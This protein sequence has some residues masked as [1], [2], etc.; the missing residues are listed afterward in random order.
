MKNSTLIEKALKL[1]S[2]GKLTDAIRL[3]KAALKSSPKHHELRFN[4]AIAQIQ[5]QS[6]DEA[7]ISLTQYVEENELDVAAWGNLAFVY[8]Q[9]A[10]F[11]EALK[12]AE[13][14]LKIFPDDISA[15]INLGVALKNLNYREKAEGV[16]NE[17]LHIDGENAQAWLNLLLLKIEEKKY[18]DVLH[19]IS[20]RPM[21]FRKTPEAREI[22][23]ICMLKLSNFLEAANVFRELFN[24]I[25]ARSPTFLSN[26]AVAEIELGNY[27]TAISLL[28][29]A[30]S[31]FPNHPTS[32]VNLGIAHNERQEYEQALNAFERAYRLRPDESFLLGRLVHQKMLC[33]Q[34]D[35][36]DTLKEKLIAGVQRKQECSEP[37]GFQAICED[38]EILRNCAETYRNYQCDYLSNRKETL[39]QHKPNQKIRLGFVSGEF[40]E[41]ATLILLIG[42]IENINRDRFEIVCF[43]NALNSDNG[44][45]RRRL[46][47]CCELIK[48][49]HLTDNQAIDCIRKSRIDILFDLNGFFGERRPAIFEAGSAPL[50]INYLGFP[51]TLGTPAMDFI[52]GDPIVIPFGSE[53]AFCERVVRM[54]Y[55]YQPTDNKRIKP[56]N[57]LTRASQNLPENA[58]VFC[59]FNNTYKITEEI[60]TVW[61]RILGEVPGSVLW[62]LGTS[63]LAEKNLKA[64]SESHGVSQDRIVFAPRTN[65]STHL[66]RHYLAD[67]FL[68]TAPYNAHT[69]AS[70]SLWMGLPVLTILGKTFPGRVAASLLSAIDVSEQLVA[71]DLQDYMTRAIR[72]GQDRDFLRKVTGFVSSG[73]DRGVLFKTEKYA[74]DFESL[75]LDLL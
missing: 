72:L 24:E 44:P 69:T 25:S 23:G 58:F 46:L 6:Y 37:F 1:H 11:Y 21:E 52:I 5:I 49:R 30:T 38:P 73:I 59:C 12:A 71:T 64:F 15:K 22:Y 55:C 39:V 63:D 35:E 27:G 57:T 20:Q 62:L 61:L 4:L 26:H 60:F 17:V 13:R 53:H 14:A 36:F 29:E 31:K 56:E 75:I 65:T 54:P 9:K 7:T 41:H 48:I 3:Y 74:R 32:W 34:W 43:D 16:F 50:Q 68:D 8:N 18:E 47:G 67:L 45:L 66:Q 33:A 70:D 19:I 40:K 28:K 10:Y 42:L 2:R 51:G